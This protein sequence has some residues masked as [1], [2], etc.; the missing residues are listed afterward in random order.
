V[1]YSELSSKNRLRSNWLKFASASLLAV[2]LAGCGG[3]SD[4]APGAAGAPGAPGASGAPGAPGASA[5]ALPTFSNTAPAATVAAN[6]AV[7]QTLAPQV[8]VTGVTIAS[9]PVVNFTVKDA[10]G[11]AVLGLGAKSQASTATVAGLTN[12]AFTL[13]KLVPGTNNEPS[14]WVSY[15]IVRVPTVAEKAGTVAA[16]TSCDSTTTPTWCGTFPSTDNQG[17]LVDN[18]DGSYSYTFLRDPKQAKAIA[19]T[20]IDTANGLNKKA[21]LGDLTFDATLTHRLGIQ[22]GGA[23]PGTGSN[24]PTGATVVPGVNMVNTANAVYDFRP[25]GAAVTNTRDIVKLDSCS[26]CHDGKVLAHGSRKDPKYCMTCHTD[27]IRYSFSAEATKASAYVLNGTTRPTTAVLDGRAIGNFPNMIHK[28]HMGKELVMSGYNFNAAAEGQYNSFGFPQDPANCTKCH[29]GSANAVNKTAN[30]DNWKNVPS[31]LACG[32]CH[33]GINFA[34]GSGLTL[35]DKAAGSLTQTGHIGGAK[36]DNA[37]CVLCHDATTIPV[38]HRGT[39]ATPNNPVVQAGVAGITYDITSVTVNAS[40]QPVIKF[41]ITKDGSPVLTLAAPALVTSATSGQQVVSPAFEPIPGFA[42]GPSLYVMFAMPQDGITAPADFNGRFS[43]S[44]TN[45]LVAAGTSPNAGTVTVDSAGL[46]TATLTGDLV[47]QAAGVGCAKPVAPAVAAC[48]NTAVLASPIVVPA[49]AKML[50]A[51]IIGTFTQKALAAYP[52]TAANV[53]VNPN[54]S[55][56]GGLIIKSLLK[57]T[58]NT[59]R[60][61]VDTAKCATCH[62]QLGTTPEFHGG[63]RNNATA[64]AFCH[65]V[66]QAGNGGWAADSS[67]FIHGIH[68]ASKRTV[69]FNWHAV[70]ATDGYWNLGYPGVLSD[71]NQCHLPNT[72]N[73]GASGTALQPNLLWSTTASGKTAAAGIATSPYVNQSAFVAGVSGANYGNNFSF[74]PAGATLGTY[75][76]SDGT[77]VAAQV[78]PVGGLIVP[79]DSATLV[80]S[81]ISAACFS[82][83]DTSTAKAHM[84][85]NGGAINEAR[86]TAMLKTESCLTC[87]GVGKDYDAA[88]VH[89]K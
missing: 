40:N 49:G 79:A 12:L 4:G 35:A 30:G 47:G 39:V 68:G 14:K 29:D 63:A 87:H 17:T 43:A 16:T 48:V 77:V 1:K 21:D 65:T 44:L 33:D 23:A 84:T 74:T 41:K 36:A 13:A 8:T 57:I 31:L 51:A 19:A 11:N 7:W 76:K 71:C 85:T 54:V 5:S 67:T 78:A 82:C 10:A 28:T 52:Y 50:T 34:A 73:F 6:A 61:I 81:P 60:A 59:R 56:K 15:N 89:H 2:A 55:A 38:Y 46:F 80:N 45:L 75:T 26:S 32:A 24:T 58:G 25:D 62:E 83:H 27:Q 86:S 42:G 88:V 18:G 53:S 20:L 22:L 70:S 64:C 3:G 72:V 37:Q 66:N 9:P 69:N